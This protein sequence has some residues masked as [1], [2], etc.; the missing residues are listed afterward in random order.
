MDLKITPYLEKLIEEVKQDYEGNDEAKAR[1]KFSCHRKVEPTNYGSSLLSDAF[2]V[3]P[4]YLDVKSVNDLNATRV[5]ALLQETFEWTV[6]R[7][8]MWFTDHGKLLVDSFLLSDAAKKYIIAKEMA[9]TFNN[10]AAL[11]TFF[12][13]GSITVFH[14]MIGMFEKRRKPVA[15]A[16]MFGNVIICAVTCTMFYFLMMM[17]RRLMRDRSGNLNATT[18]GRTNLSE[19]GK[20]VRNHEKVEAVDHEYYK[21]GVEYYSKIV[22]RNIALRNLIRSLPYSMSNPVINDDGSWKKHFWTVEISAP[23]QLQD[24]HD[25]A[26]GKVIP[27]SKKGSLFS[28][29]KKKSQ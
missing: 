17:Q 2:V 26:V 9:S 29:E 16:E 22:Q 13:V 27:Q 21:G 5:N 18:R 28:L 3:L 1:V 11:M 4:E 23:E 6:P 7:T 15:A 12:L 8:E 10:D 20:Q 19:A 14:L 24:L 25:W